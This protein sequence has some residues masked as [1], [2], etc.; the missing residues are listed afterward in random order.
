MAITAGLVT[1]LAIELGLDA[2]LVKPRRA[3]GDMP[4]AHATIREVHTDELEITTQPVEQGALITDHAFKRPSEC[5][6][7]IGYS[8]SPG[9]STLLGSVAS[10]VTGM[11]AGVSSL[12]TG[13]SESEVRSIYERFLK[14]QNDREP[15]DVYTGKRVYAN[16]LVK[17]LSTETTKETENSMVLKVHLQQVILV[18]TATTSS[19]SAAPEDQASPSDTT[20]TSDEGV[21]QPVDAPD[22]N[23]SAGDASIDNPTSSGTEVFT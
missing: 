18:P 17:A 21:K 3:I 9:A 6:V 14:L 5:I 12:L 15:F 13:N 8:N 20:P 4:I 1:Q 19:V 23:N 11:I 7:E 16:M 2:L 10:A 22:Y